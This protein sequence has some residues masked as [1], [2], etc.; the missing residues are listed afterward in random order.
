M[1]IAIEIETQTPQTP[2][3]VIRKLHRGHRFRWW[4]R[5]ALRW[6]NRR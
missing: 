1:A 2:H 6:R 3:D 4:Q 5:F